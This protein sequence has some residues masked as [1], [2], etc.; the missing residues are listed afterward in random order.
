MDIDTP[1]GGQRKN[2]VG[3]EA[4][5]G[6]HHDQLRLQLPQNGQG[7]PV[8]QG[9]RLIDGDTAG[10]GTGLHRGGLEL[11]VVPAHR[12][13][14]LTEHAHHLMPRLRQSLQRGDGKFWGAHEDDSHLLRRLL[15][16]PWF[17]SSERMASI[18]SEV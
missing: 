6:R 8:P 7:G 15:L 18:S 10:Q 13:V 12:P 9:L 2:I 17:S 16:L 14:R 11:I 5:I 3:E 4:A 1:L